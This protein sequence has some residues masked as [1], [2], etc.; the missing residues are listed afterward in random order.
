ML[1]N[2]AAMVTRTPDT[3][4]TVLE[5]PLEMWEAFFRVNVTGAYLMSR[6]VSRIMIGDR[7]RGRIVN[8]TSTASESARVGAAHYC[9]S[10]AALAM[11]TRVLALELA[12]H[13]ITVN[14]VSPGYIQVTQGV[15]MTPGRKEYREAFLRGIPV[16]RAGRPEE[17]ARAV[18]F[19]AEENS[20]YITGENIRVDGGALAG[21]SH[22]PRSA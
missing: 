11:F 4:A 9:C 17:I 19:L 20:E 7:V 16:N 12:P 10:K 3:I 21:R 13:G 6:E 8:I 22:L 5:A 18:L 15:P 14:S 1:V 2:N